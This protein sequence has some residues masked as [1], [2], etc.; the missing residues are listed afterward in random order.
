MRQFVRHHVMLHPW[1]RHH[2]PPLEHHRAASRA[3]AP[4]AAR[5][6]HRDPARRQPRLGSQPRRQR[7]QAA[8]GLRAQQVGHPPLQEA[9]VPGHVDLTGRQ[10][11]PA[12]AGRDVPHDVKLA[13]DRDGRTLGERQRRR[14]GGQLVA[15]P[16]CVTNQQAQAGRAAGADGEGDDHRP[17]LGVDSQV[18]PARARVAPPP[19]GGGAMRKVN[20]LA[21]GCRHGWT[22]AAHLSRGKP[23]RENQLRKVLPSGFRGGPARPWHAAGPL[24]HVAVQRAG[25][26]FAH[27]PAADRDAGFVHARRVP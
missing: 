15:D 3:T 16:G 1:R 21:E 24:R 8:P 27:H 5:V 13:A 20:D 18:D 26:L 14:Q 7:A 22:M 10:P 6:A 2:Q 19:H 4:A 17:R 25:V 23:L 11:S 9:V 12:P